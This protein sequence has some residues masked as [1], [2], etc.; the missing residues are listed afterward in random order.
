M[1]L[2]WTTIPAP[3]PIRALTCAVADDGAL[4]HVGWGPHPDLLV[5]LARTLGED[6]VVDEGRT[7]DAVTQ[8]AEY[9][10]GRRRVFD[11]QV[12]WRSMHGSRL[13]VLRTLHERVPYGH[14][15][16]YGELAEMSGAF[17]A[18]WTAAR[19]VGSIMGS[20]PVPLVGVVRVGRSV[21][22][23]TP[24]CRCRCAGCGRWRAP[25]RAPTG[26]S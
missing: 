16:G 15:V 10:D 1:S 18:S 19:G 20:N 13:T 23:G 17:D 14:V 11:L 26:S 6:V 5:A 7:R 8:L 22:S 21:R 12:D 4:A 9:L 3:G 2:A 25:R 24:G